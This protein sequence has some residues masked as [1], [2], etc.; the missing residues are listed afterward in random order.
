M[1]IESWGART[2]KF[3]FLISIRF[4]NTWNVYQI[5][6]Q[7][8]RNSFTICSDATLTSPLGYTE[9][10]Q[11][12]F[13]YMN[14]FVYHPD[15]PFLKKYHGTILNTLRLIFVDF[16]CTLQFISLFTAGSVIELSTVL[17]LASN[18]VTVSLKDITFM[19]KK[20][21]IYELWRQLDDDEFKVKTS[22][23]FQYVSCSHRILKLLLS[24]L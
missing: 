4:N 22:D 11:Q 17:F 1:T 20:E 23:E 3:S 21:D 18:W 9:K 10:H 13:R 7:S 24:N 15:S 6:V 12:K 16:G 2:P 5:I 19:R 14:I 8:L